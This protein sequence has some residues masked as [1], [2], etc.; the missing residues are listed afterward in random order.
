MSLHLFLLIVPAFAPV[1]ARQAST[2][3]D[4][5]SYA[6][7]IAGQGVRCGVPPRAQRP[8]P[9]IEIPS[10]CGFEMTNPSEEY[11]P[12]TMFEIPVVVHVIEHSD[13]TGHLTPEQVQSQIDVLNE[14]FL[15][16]PGT[17][18]A[19]GT[20]ARIQFRLATVD[21]EGLP[22]SGITYT[23]NDFW[24][25]DNGA[26]WNALAWDTR[27]FLNIYVNDLPEDLIG[28]A[29]PAQYGLAGLDEDRVVVDWI[30]FG[31]NAAY[32]PPYDQGRT[33]THEIGHYLGLEHTFEG[34]CAG[35]NCYATGDLICDTNEVAFENYGCD[36]SAA[37]CGASDP[38]HNYMD[39][40]DD[41]CM[42][43]F[44][45]EQVRRMR[46]TLIHWRPDLA[47]VGP[48]P[49]VALNIDI[50]AGTPVPGGSFGA[51]AEQSGVWSAVSAVDAMAA[52]KALNNLAGEP[53]TAT[54]EASGGGGDFAADN[55]ATSGDD[56]SL[57]DDL[58]DVVD[59]ATWTLRGLLPGSYM[60]YVYSWAPDDPSFTS[61]VTILGGSRGAQTCGGQAWT[62]SYIEGAHY[63]V[64]RVEASGGEISVQV[65]PTPAQTPA[66]LNGIQVV[67]VSPDISTYCMGK[68]N[69]SGCVPFISFSGAPSASS[70]DPFRIVANQLVPGQIGMLLYSV[71]GKAN[72][73]FHGGKLC[74]KSPFRRLLPPKSA[75]PKGIPP[76]AGELITNFNNRIQSGADPALTI[77]QRVHAQW[78][79]RDPLDPQGFGDSLTDGIQF[80]IDV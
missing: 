38:I 5:S 1:H 72:L 70:P 48:E 23:V 45:P 60:V 17:N 47:V 79:Q 75:S 15:A 36:T 30:V 74:V 20:D 43:E 80:V 13:G 52:P 77:G 14:D 3:I 24:F 29:Y 35:G 19:G 39:Y 78:R 76:C 16:L 41:L 40:T 64:D 9:L 31:R 69:S 6:Q 8:A 54:L 46:C 32:G 27:R 51:A 44:T 2:P 62:G 55:P 22:T 11:A 49:A 7:S 63:V 37:S 59:G 65:G 73:N 34:G 58:H 71:N 42:W 10:D 67:A 68:T 21:A 57:L 28:Y 66:S 53:T 12:T 18:G 4:L 61:E 33:A 50:G 56:E 25:N 26:Y